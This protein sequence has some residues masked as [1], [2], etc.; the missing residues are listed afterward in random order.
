MKRNLKF[1]IGF[2]PVQ[3]LLLHVRRSWLLLFFWFILFAMA[4]GF[5][6]KPIGIA[7]LFQSP[8][9]LGDVNFLSYF[10]MGLVLGFF[11]MAFHI[12]SYIFYSFR[13]TFLAAT[14]RPLYRFSINN[15]IIPLVFYVF[16][17]YVIA[18]AMLLD[19]FTVWQ[20]L[21]NQAGVFLGS[22]VSIS[23]TFTYFFS[24]MRSFKSEVE[25]K[26]ERPF[27]FIIRKEKRM[28]SNANDEH[29]FTYLRNFYKIRRV[30]PAGH[31]DEVDRL[32]TLQQHHTSAA[33]YFVALLVVML[34]LN[35]FS[36]MRY[37]VIPAGASI[38]LIL[39]TYLM[40]FGALFSWLKTWTITFIF[41]V[42]LITNAIS[43]LSY[44]KVS[45]KA[46]GLNY[47]SAPL[48][49]T[50]D[51]LAAL[52]T[53]SIIAEDKKA[54]LRAL[55]GWKSRQ[56]ESKPLLVIFNN[57]GGGLRSSLFTLA[58]MQYLDSASTGKFY[59]RIFLMAGS[60]GGMIGSAYYRELKLQHATGTA[61]GIN[62]KRYFDLLG[63]D[64]LNSVGFS[65]AVNDF[66]LPIKTFKKAGYRY[67]LDRGVAWDNRL[68]LNT[69]NILNKSVMSY[70]NEESAGKIPLLVLSPTIINRAQ[71]LLF[72]PMGL[73]FLSIYRPEYQT[74]KTDLY[75]GVEYGRFFADRQADSM[76]FTTALRMS[77][78]FP[79]ITP[80]VGLPTEPQMEVL[81][82]GA[83]DN[84]GLLLT[85]R[86]MHEFKDW[87]AA[88]TCGVLVIQTLAS[89]PIDE[90]IKPTDYNT[91]FES[92]VKPLGAMVQSFGTLQGFARAEMLTY[93]GDWMNFPFKVIQLDLLQHS[94]EVS[95]SWH[96]T[97]REKMFIYQTIRG[98]RLAPKFDAIIEDCN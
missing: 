54:M 62:S 83:R 49:Y 78:T 92:L 4:G 88:N 40:V 41:V 33:I 79:Y 73:S 87:I 12:A 11:V 69:N 74:R 6:F 50:Y 27:R 95:L 46:P 61:L 97:E 10:L 77:S 71:R 65:M 8:E 26:L 89:R 23:L 43:G 68:N 39:T 7:Y 36:G 1:I 67:S 14:T 52:T 55:E 35:L 96:L 5:L 81:D 90:L 60:S 16:Y 64:I 13:Y 51:A 19:G 53:D 91:R 25:E 85:L 45:A 18:K 15:S 20:I 93:A 31:Y 80:V 32:R 42:V 98:E 34:I 59:N 48:P 63:T 86:F 24:T 44:F 58:A 38:V 17:G 72:S 47:A 76:S 37:T 57:S 70:R 84:D 9:Y 21:L 66:F 82:A 3:L 2:F 94:D 29:V 28:D 30:R 22:I 75:D 56:G